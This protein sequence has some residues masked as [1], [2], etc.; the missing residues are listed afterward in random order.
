MLLAFIKNGGV[1]KLSRIKKPKD[2]KQIIGFEAIELNCYLLVEE[3]KP[4]I[5]LTKH[6]ITMTYVEGN[7]NSVLGQAQKK[8]RG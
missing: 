5:P 6:Q 8:C 7:P 3:I 1:Y 4:L 2:F